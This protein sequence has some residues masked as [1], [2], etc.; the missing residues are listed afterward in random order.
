MLGVKRGTVSFAE[1][2]GRWAAEAEKTIEKLRPVFGAAA[3]YEP[4][5]GTAVPGACAV[6][7]LDIAVGVRSLREILPLAPALEKE[8]FSRR[9]ENDGEGRIAFFCGDARTK[10]VT[11]NIYVVRFGGTD[12]ED[13]LLFRDALRKNGRRA[14]EYEA[15]RRR[16]AREYPL[17]PAAYARGKAGFIA[18]ALEEARDRALLGGRVRVALSGPDGE[19]RRGFIAGENGQRPA[20][21]LGAGAGGTFDGTVF[22]VLRH[23][24]EEPALVA[25]PDEKWLFEAELRAA[26]A[27]LGVPEDARLRCLC[28]K[29]C[30]AVLFREKNGIRRFLLVRSVDGHAG[31]PKGHA[32]RG[33]T[34]RRTA[35]RELFEE[36][37]LKAFFLEGFREAVRYVTPAGVRKESVYFAAALVRGEPRPQPE[38]ISETLLLPFEEARRTVTFPADRAVLEKAETWLKKR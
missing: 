12:W 3:A 34:E 17:D 29:S 2:D 4:V 19:A 26:L 6:P 35:A 28:E 18:A 37:G 16:L 27:P 21:A 22:G 30:G 7:V 11:G 8:G 14:K 31:F 1:Y 5:G 24:A 10:T 15:L 38:E 25:A 9:P 13:F 23:G 33:E 32:E 20:F 36:T